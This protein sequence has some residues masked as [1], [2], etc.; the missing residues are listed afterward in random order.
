MCAP[1]TS[2]PRRAQSVG[3]CSD[4]LPSTRQEAVLGACSGEGVQLGVGVGQEQK[5]WILFSSPKEVKQRSEEET[6]SSKLVNPI[7][8]EFILQLPVPTWPSLDA[9]WEVRK[10]IEAP[11]TYLCACTPTK[12]TKAGRRCL[13]SL[14]SW[15][16]T[17]W[18]RLRWQRSK[19]TSSPS[20]RLEGRWRKSPTILSTLA[21]GRRQTEHR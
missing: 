9:S 2:H 3:R 21:W 16:L 18:V 20:S 13:P 1:H 11:A 10:G 7:A 17:S 19:G 14:Q 15:S 6:Q 8:L 12:I 4:R 5:T